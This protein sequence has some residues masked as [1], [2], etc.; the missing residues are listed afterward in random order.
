MGISFYSETIQWVHD[1]GKTKQA[2]TLRVTV[3]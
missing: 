2:K 3:R 1:L